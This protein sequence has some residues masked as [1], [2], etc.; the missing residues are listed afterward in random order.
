MRSSAVS[1]RLPSIAVESV[2]IAAQALARAD[3]RQRTLAS[4]ARDDNFGLL[5]ADLASSRVEQPFGPAVV[6]ADEDPS[7]VEAVR[8]SYQNSIR[9]APPGSRSN[10]AGEA[11]LALKLSPFRQSALRTSRGVERARLIRCP[12]AELQIPR[13]A[14]QN[15]RRPRRRDA[16]DR[17][18]NPH[19]AAQRLPM[20]Q[21]GALGLPA[22]SRGLA[23]FRFGVKHEAVRAMLL[24]QHHPHRRV[25]GRIGGGERH[26]FGVVG[27]APFAS[28]NHSS[29][30]AKGSLVI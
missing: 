9:S 10:A 13:R 2:A 5:R 8:P 7:L 18:F 20:E 26:R 27:L 25:A 14:S 16:L 30:R 22:S 21:Q 15:R 23:A 6:G 12:G 1:A 4:A 11:R 28:A 3:E 29:N 17:A 24:Q 19:L